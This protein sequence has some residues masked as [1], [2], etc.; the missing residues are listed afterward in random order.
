[1]SKIDQKVAEFA[2]S[3]DTVHGLLGRNIQLAKA[4]LEILDRFVLK[5]DEYCSYTKPVAGTTAFVKFE[6]EGKAVDAAALCK[7]VQEKT[8]V[9]FL[10][11]DV[12]FGE[13]FK[14]YV[15]IG[16]CNQTQIV[17]EGFEELRKFMRREVDE[18][19][20]AE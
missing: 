8:G 5:H 3:P 16:Y 13:Q 4:N 9:M 10:P 20:L 2:L 17:K 19:P 11:G 7:A 14:G 1:V 15:R 18:V 6:R 12:G